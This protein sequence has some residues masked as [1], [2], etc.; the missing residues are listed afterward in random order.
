MAIIKCPRCGQE[1][2]DMV[3]EPKCPNCGCNPF[4]ENA[5]INLQTQ[6][7]GQSIKRKNKVL[8]GFLSLFFWGVGAHQ[9]YLGSIPKALLC[10]FISIAINVISVF[11]PPFRFL[12]MLIGV[13]CAIKL[14]VMSNNNFDAKY[15]SPTSPKTKTGCLIIMLFIGIIIPLILGILAAIFLPQYLSSVEKARVNEILPILDNISAAQY[16][17]YL[18]A[19]KFAQNFDVFDVDIMDSNGYIRNTG[20]SFEDKNFI[21]SLKGNGDNAYVEAERKGDK[22]HYAIRK[23]YL[24]NKLQCVP[25][26]KRDISICRTVG[27]STD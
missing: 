13:I 1:F 2:S 9:L 7:P 3:T 15:N 21:I 24:T 5:D 10:I 17:G 4:I 12:L 20:T 27:I 22:Q 11:I 18:R 6:Q 26:T 25:G 16:R 8:A 23:Y 19:N 14:F